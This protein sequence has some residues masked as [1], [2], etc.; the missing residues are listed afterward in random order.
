MSITLEQL[1]RGARSAMLP[2][3]PAV[4]GSV[5]TPPPGNGGDV[6]ARVEAFLS[7]GRAPT[8]EVP[9]PAPKAAAPAPAKAALAPA[10]VK[11]DPAKLATMTNYAASTLL[12]D[13]YRSGGLS[14]DEYADAHKQ[15]F[16]TDLRRMSA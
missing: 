15:R 12:A 5:A 16:G 9:A 7:G 6:W 8:K 4:A 11:P 2:S 14:W 13:E 3:S 10:R 1:E